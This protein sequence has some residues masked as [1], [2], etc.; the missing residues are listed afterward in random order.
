M[1]YNRARNA[2]P[3]PTEFGRDPVRQ[4]WTI[5]VLRFAFSLLVVGVMVIGIGMLLGVNPFSP[6]ALVV[7]MLDNGLW[8]LVLLILAVYAIIS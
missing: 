2:E 8:W 1:V 5:V 3:E 7:A 6:V 4:R